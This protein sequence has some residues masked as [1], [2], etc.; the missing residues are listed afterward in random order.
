METIQLKVTPG[1]KGPHDEVECDL[2]S[3]SDYLVDE[4]LILPHDK[5]FTLVFELDQN[6]PANWDLD[7]PFCARTGK[8]PPRKAQAHS[9]VRQT[10][11]D[12][13]RLEVEARAPNAKSVIHYR[14]N[15][16]DGTTF[17]PIIIHTV[18]SK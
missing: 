1:P 13:R 14:L 3:H 12:K 6:A 9:H 7:N 15:F 11:V 10:Q 5:D 18:A 16:D 17:D 2:A 4:A 8:C